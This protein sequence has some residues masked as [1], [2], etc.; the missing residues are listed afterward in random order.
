LLALHSISGTQLPAKLG[1]VFQYPSQR[2]YYPNILGV[3][4][5]IIGNPIQF[6]LLVFFSNYVPA[7]FMML[8]KEHVLQLK[9]VPANI[10]LWL[11]Q[12]RFAQIV[13]GII[14]PLSIAIWGV[15]VDMESFG[16]TGGLPGI[17]GVFLSFLGRYV[18][19]AIIIQ[20]LYVFLILNLFYITPKF[21]LNHPDGC[22]GFSP[23]GN[24]GFAIYIFLFIFALTEAVVTAIALA[25]NNSASFTAFVYLWI[26]F[27]VITAFVFDGLIY[28]PH[29]VLRTAR[30]N[31]LLESSRDWNGFYQKVISGLGK[32]S[33]ENKEQAK[34]LDE[35]IKILEHWRKLDL[36][37]NDMHVW[38]IS[39]QRL[40]FI[41]TLGSPFIPILLPAIVESLK[42]WF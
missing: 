30:D 28:K 1:D 26:L 12:N 25:N 17:Y 3:A 23:F 34:Q 19:T 35:N 42:S 7:Q 9:P 16:S 2:F 36:Y 32:F 24:L 27:P 15:V 18:R 13:M 20:L 8:E 21:S 41:S 40:Q 11:C 39:K 5:D 38:P 29:A 14:V 10:Y 31:L 6:A 22:S 37:T 4:Y 33:T